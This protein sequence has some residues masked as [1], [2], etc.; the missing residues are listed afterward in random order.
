MVITTKLQDPITGIAN[1]KPDF[2]NEVT[3]NGMHNYKF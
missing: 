2:R 1:L 3:I